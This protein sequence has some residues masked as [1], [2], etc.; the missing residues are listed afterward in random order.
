MRVL[1]SSTER[2]VVTYAE[3]IGYITFKISTVSSRGWPDRV[4]IDPNGYHIYIELKQAGKKPRKLQV[5]RIQQL[6]ERKVEVHW[7]DSFSAVKKILDQNLGLD[8]HE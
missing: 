8:E 6:H 4:F 7:T 5:H 3:S 1:E 2:K